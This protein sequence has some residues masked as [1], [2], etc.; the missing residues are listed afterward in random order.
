MLKNNTYYYNDD[1]MHTIHGIQYLNKI[2][3]PSKRAL[4]FLIVKQQT[5]LFCIIYFVDEN[6]DYDSSMLLTALQNF[7]QWK[8]YVKRAFGVVCKLN[9]VLRVFIG[10]H[11]KKTDFLKLETTFCMHFIERSWKRKWV[12]QLKISRG[13]VIIFATKKFNL[14]MMNFNWRPCVLCLLGKESS[15]Y[16]G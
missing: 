7:C 13:F 10:A 16:R 11:C 5:C 3:N 12:I 14:M 8:T 1:F 4:F 6:D 15:V 2:E 9:K